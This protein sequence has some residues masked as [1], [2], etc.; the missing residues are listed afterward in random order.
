MLVPVYVKLKTFE[1][2]IHAQ[3]R[4][5]IRNCHCFNTSEGICWMIEIQLGQAPVALTEHLNA[6]QRR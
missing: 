4:G 2:L 6:A 3:R 5:I 1:I